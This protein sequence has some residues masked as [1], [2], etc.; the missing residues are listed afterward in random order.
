MAFLSSVND[1]AIWLSITTF[2]FLF[3]LCL[4]YGVYRFQTLRALVIIQKRFPRLVLLE[5]LSSLI[6]LFAAIPL[7][8]YGQL[9]APHHPPILIAG[10]CLN[11]LCTH[12]IANI[13]LCRLWLMSF[14]LNYLHSSSNKQWKLQIDTS[15]DAKDWYLVQRRRWGSSPYVL[16]RIAVFYL[17]VVAL[18]LTLYVLTVTGNGDGADSMASLGAAMAHLANGVCY[19]IPVAGCL[20]IYCRIPR[21]LND[22]LLF[23]YEFTSTALI[24]SSGLVVYMMSIIPHFISAVPIVLHVILSAL[25]TICAASLPSLLSTVAH[26]CTFQ[27]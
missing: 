7:Y 23:Q 8:V 21:G 11:Q 6:L 26:F 2:S 1:Q 15:F 16:R 17:C 20:I 27:I 3:G 4:I 19:S 12:F 25:I 9:C 13:E 14:E 10:L 5:S 22:N 18:T 24:F